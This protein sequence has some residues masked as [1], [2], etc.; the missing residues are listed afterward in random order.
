[1]VHL[2]ER[3]GIIY[4]DKFVEIRNV[5]ERDHEFLMDPQ[6]I[7]S[8]LDGIQAIVHSHEEICYPSFRDIENMWTWRVPWIIVA[9]NCIK[10]FLFADSSVTE[11]DVDSLLPEE[12]KDL[13]VHLS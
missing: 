7:Y 12:L 10:A 5:S 6:E 9:P 11:I 2:R 13:I 4:K 3:C 8:Y 1:M